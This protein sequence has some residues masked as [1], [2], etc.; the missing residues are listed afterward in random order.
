MQAGRGRAKGEEKRGRE[1]QG[2]TAVRAACAC[3]C[4][5][6]LLEEFHVIAVSCSCYLFFTADENAMKTSLNTLEWGMT[7]IV[8]LNGRKSK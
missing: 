6:P 5:V 7:S 2:G 1:R 4:S 8:E 3:V